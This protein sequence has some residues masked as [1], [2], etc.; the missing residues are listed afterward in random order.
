MARRLTTHPLPAWVGDLPVFERTLAN[1]FKALVLPRTHAPV[2]ICDL[3]YPVGSVNEP[4]GK[5]GLAHFVEH[6][7]FKGTE[8]FPK[9]QIDRLAFIAA[10]QSNAE[11]GE[12]FTHYWFSF[13]SDRWELALAIEADRMQGATFDPREVEAERH[14][15]G[16]ERARDLDSPLGRLDQTH[17]AV[18]YLRHPYRNPILGWPDDL[19]SITVADLRDFY[20]RHYRPDGAVLVVVGDV[21]PDRALDRIEAHFGALCLGRIERREPMVGEPRQ[22]GRRDFTLVDSESA[23]R[24]L[25]G[26]HTV[27]RGDPDGPALDVL[28]D[29]LTCGRRSR[30]WS[31]L[32][33][34]E[35]IATWVEASQDGAHRAGQ[36][37]VQ[38]EAPAEI[39]PLRIEQAIGEVFGRL[40]DDG[41][42]PEEL[43]RARHR[44]EAAWR[45]EQ[46]DL[47]GLAAGLGQVALWGDWRAWQ[48]EHR[49]A[50]AVEADDIR[51]VVSTYLRD[52]NLTAG[53]SLPRPNR[54]I[55]V[56]L[57][58]ETVAMAPRPAA[59]PSPDR[60][61][62]LAIPCGGTR[63]ADYHP[64]RAVLP[65]GMRL[66]SERR[67][68]TGIVALELFVEAG[69]LR[70]A[71][72]GLAY[73]TGRLLEE[74]T[75]NRSADALAE[76]IED[77]GGTLDVGST[78]ASLR[79]RA[80]DLSLA[81]ELL[82]D[83]IRRPAFPTEALA[84]AKRRTAAELQADRDD[85][86]FRADLI[87]RGLVYGDH[88]Y[89]RDPRGTTREIARLGR[90]DVRAHHARHFTADD[91]F[92]VAVGDFEPRRLA[93][94]VKAQFRSWPA[95]GEPAPSLA[96][97]VRSAR[98]RVRRVAHPGEQV[99]IVLGHLGIPRNHPDFDALTVLDHILGSG[100]GFTDRL[101]RLLRDE[102]GLAYS[103]GG[104]ITDSADVAP[105]L[106]RIH[107]GTM[108]DETDH[109]VAAIVD[110]VRAMHAGAFSDD[111]VD[112]ARRYLS[113]SWVFD[114]QTVEQRAERLLELERWEL[115]LDEPVRWPERIARIT[116]RQVRRAARA[117]LA[118]AALTRIEFGP[119][120]RRGQRA[121]AECA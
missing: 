47:A 104:G 30:L 10:G 70:E 16:E 118:P 4:A 54:A 15:I 32:V 58:T 77:I 38:V 21:E 101:S 75:Q 55:T 5:T 49:A 69:L 45:W 76:A 96:R 3:Y 84:W 6:M 57:P 64:R 44:L 100:P 29:L 87:F 60:P 28:S 105:G 27:P 92:L 85:P 102:M 9:G 78:G 106:F 115:G 1:G 65:N 80:E 91:A 40:G 34:R 13:P 20:Q 63:L 98:P 108:P 42:T 99:Q 94:L 67:P 53:W 48:A 103:V 50:L 18:T 62:A 74:G 109:V 22:T 82:A 12:D 121:R 41:P 89:A 36:F 97:P 79:V 113:G 119:I 90:D 66:I 88:P 25:L 23:V 31:A 8:R 112:R 39:E 33:E 93:S 71:K 72:P 120:R 24:G 73:L 46:E 17:L 68:G 56:L 86:A 26:W 110:Q 111:E 43:I 114:F 7:L 83:V 14:V 52:A 51:R 11:T 19:A 37:L 59:S 61:I 107:V 35:R 2:V 95:R 116:P 117:H 81:L